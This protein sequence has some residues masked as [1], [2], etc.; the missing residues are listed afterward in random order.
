MHATCKM[1]WLALITGPCECA[2]LC[3][4]VTL[5]HKHMRPYVKPPSGLTAHDCVHAH[6][7]PIWHCWIAG[8]TAQQKDRGSVAMKWV[9][10]SVLASSRIAATKGMQASTAGKEPP[11]K[12]QKAQLA[13][14]FRGKHCHCA[15]QLGQQHPH[16]LMPWCAAAE[17]C[18]GPSLY[19]VCRWNSA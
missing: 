18:G 2:I 1:W 19:V 3:T 15:Q 5:K 4:P 13:Q 6:R 16:L 10:Q 14:A 9:R 8:D 12:R 17:D 7:E 11:G